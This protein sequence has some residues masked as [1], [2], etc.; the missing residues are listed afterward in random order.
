ME[1]RLPELAEGANSGSVVSILVSE[2]DRIQ[3]GQPLLE[4]ENQK[5]VAPIPSPIAG[6][7]TRIHVKQGD[8]VSV[9]QALVSISEGNGAAAPVKE[10]P[11]AQGRRAPEPRAASPAQ[12]AAPPGD[13][14]YD[15]KSGAPPPASPSVRRL[16]Q[17]L[18]IDL[19]RVRGSERGGRITA[20][21]LRAY[22]Q[23]LQQAPPSAASAPPAESIDFSK[24]GPVTKKPITPLRRAIAAAMSASWNEIPH[25]TQFEEADPS[26]ILEWKEKYSAAYEQKKGPLTPTV[27][28]LK[29]VASVLKK[30]RG[31]NASLDLAAGQIVYK[32]YV[33]I[34]VAVDTEGGLIVPVLKEVD[35]KEMLE[36]AQQL[37]QLVKRTRERKVA[38][39]DLQGGTFTIS[40]QGGI[41][42]S[43]FTPIIRKPE[44]AIL[45]VGRARQKRLPLSLSYDHRAVDGADAARFIVELVQTIEDFPEKWVK[46]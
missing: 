19:N 42:G 27:F 6:T 35:K 46:P 29:A 23:A 41:G 18:G 14:R 30:H 15:S 8:N 33:H 11:Q 4:L 24:W 25:V 20:E 16:A 34:G 45:G 13:Y 7:V 12:A 22:V 9:G 38:A 40:N 36:I 17:Q 21:D 37:D 43:F 26:R 3:K 44:V 39:E 2:G 10:K 28:L 1:V 31:F 5:A 32:E